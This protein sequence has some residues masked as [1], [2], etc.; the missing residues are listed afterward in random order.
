MFCLFS[1]ESFFYVSTCFRSTETHSEVT[2]LSLQND[3][4]ECSHN[5]EVLVFLNN[6]GHFQNWT[7]LFQRTF[8]NTYES[9][10]KMFLENI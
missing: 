10:N 2:F 8:E 1:F 5:Q 9:V 6:L 4:M 3:Q 7:V